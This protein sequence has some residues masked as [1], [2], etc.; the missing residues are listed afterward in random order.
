M[1]A[2]ITIQ[3]FGNIEFYDSAINPSIHLIDTRS[4]AEITAALE[5]LLC[6]RMPK[7]VPWEWLRKNTRLSA[8]ILLNNVAFSVEAKVGR[9]YLQFFA[10][11]AQGQDVTNL[12]RNILWHCSEQDAA[13][14]FDGQGQRFPSVLCRYRNYKDDVYTSEL[15][16]G[17]NRIA[18]M[19]AFRAYLN[20]YIRNF[21]PEPINCQKKYQ[22]DIDAKGRFLVDDP[23][24]KGAVFLSETEEKLFRYHCFLNVAEFWQGFEQIRNFHSPKKPLII[25]NFLEFLDESVQVD[26]L[27][28]RTLQLGRQVILLT[29]SQNE[30]IPIQWK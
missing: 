7:E 23:D 10:T 8:Q 6:N 4:G 27:L 1:I 9:K 22:I 12:Y 20:R 21:Q 29:H 16:A 5:V 26:D 17:T 28:Q 18:T 30:N 15:I 13:E 19:K 24:R 25:S 3:N 11:D 2:H 14:K